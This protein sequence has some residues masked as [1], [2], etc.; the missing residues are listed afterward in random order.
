M[1]R[2]LFVVLY[3]LA[4]IIVRKLI[5]V[6]FDVSNGIWIQNVAFNFRFFIFLIFI[7]VFMNKMW[8]LNFG[9]LVNKSL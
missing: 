6:F 9:V 7:F 3:L 1:H 4:F 5:L 8:L 2:F